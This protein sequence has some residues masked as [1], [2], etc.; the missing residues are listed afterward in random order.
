MRAK[1]NE[2]RLKRVFSVSHEKKRDF[3]FFVVGENHHR[4]F[5]S[6]STTNT[7]FKRKSIQRRDDL[8]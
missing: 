8:N 6:K 7:A 1:R 4:P 5:K 3:L 2:S